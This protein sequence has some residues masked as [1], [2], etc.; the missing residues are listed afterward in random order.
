M[1]R[2]L[3]G[4]LMQKR[5][6]AVFLDVYLDHEEKQTFAPVRFEKQT[7]DGIEKDVVVPNRFFR[8]MP[9]NRKARRLVARLNRS[10]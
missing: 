10:R 2:F 9:R 5:Q 1:R 8:R 3:L 6:E 4:E 7:I